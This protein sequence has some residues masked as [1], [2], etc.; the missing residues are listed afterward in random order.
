MKLLTFSSDFQPYEKLNLRENMLIDNIRRSRTLAKIMTGFA[1]LSAAAALFYKSH[2]INLFFMHLL[3]I[4]VNI[5]FLLYIKK[6]KSLKNIGREML[7]SLEKTI[8]IYITLL[9]CLSSVI[10]LIELKFHEQT[11][12][13]MIAL[14]LCS[15]LYYADNKKI[16]VP[17][18]FSVIIPI[19]GL[20]FSETSI[21]FIM[22]HCV[23]IIVFS[24][25][26]WLCSRILY[27]NHCSDLKN[28]LLLKKANY[29]LQEL[30]LIDELTGLPN[31]RGLNRYIKF[32]STCNLHRALF[33]SIIMIDIDFF[34]QYNDNYGHTAGDTVLSL[35]AEQIKAVAESSSD[36]AARFGG[37]EF[38]YAA[39]NAD[40]KDIKKKA[41]RI[42]NKVISLNIPHSASAASQF[43]SVSLGTATV[44][45][46]SESK[47]LKCIDL[48]DKALYM[49]KANGKN[50]VHS[51]D[52]KMMI[53]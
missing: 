5:L 37:E 34:K 26:A 51:I 2:F 46:S 53:M 9:I 41:E 27:I 33:V 29:E 52:E 3:I 50:C 49:A 22:Y 6:F 28:R 4:A 23:N 30:S 45:A 13:Y 48:A 40:E 12:I 36:F 43:I 31:R 11:V 21:G 8:L 25:M 18:S 24:L 35:V 19:T 42:R 7:N 14:M 1:A 10:S 47:I 38:I 15:V 16:L 44:K 17:F 39:V 20:A 32:I